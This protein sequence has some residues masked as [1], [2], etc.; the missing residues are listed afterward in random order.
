MSLQELHVS[1]DVIFHNVYHKLKKNTIF[2]Y[3]GKEFPSETIFVQAS[4]IVL[5][6]LLRSFSQSLSPKFS[7][8]KEILFSS[9]SKQTFA[10]TAQKAFFV[11]LIIGSSCII[12]QPIF[13]K[14]PFLF[15]LA[16]S[17]LSRLTLW[18]RKR[19]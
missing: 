5:L 19:G 6:Y 12:H 9:E 1:E 16:M 14:K 11:F 10:Q 4:I 17:R 7:F 2:F 18:L 13:L 3:F 15:L 8:A